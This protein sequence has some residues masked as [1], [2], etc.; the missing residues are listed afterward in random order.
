MEKPAVPGEPSTS[1]FVISLS[2]TATKEEKLKLN[3]VQQLKCMQIFLP[4]L[5]KEN[6]SM[7]SGSRL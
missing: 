3:F 7:N 1:T 5:C 4:N 6:N 2:L